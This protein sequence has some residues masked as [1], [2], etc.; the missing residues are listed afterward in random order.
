MRPITN[1]A[2]T[3]SG[4]SLCA[5]TAE[6]KVASTGRAVKFRRASALD[7]VFAVHTRVKRVED[8]EEIKSRLQNSSQIVN[9]YRC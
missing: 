1:Y 4:P 2:R 9:L 7:D 8:L 3:P 5:G 6:A